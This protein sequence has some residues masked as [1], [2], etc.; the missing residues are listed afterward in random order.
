MFTKE[1]Y[2][3]KNLLNDYVLQLDGAPP[4]FTGMYESYSIV[5]SNRAGSDGGQWRQPHTQTVWDGLGYRVDVCRVTQGTHSEG[6]SLMHKKLGQLPL[7]TVYVLP[8]KVRNK[9]L[10]NF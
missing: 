8:W 1:W 10:V 3:F 7:L 9:L 5:F 6:L 4:I 2:G